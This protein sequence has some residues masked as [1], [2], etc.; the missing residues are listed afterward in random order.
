MQAKRVKNKVKCN[1]IYTSEG[2]VLRQ[3]KAELVRLKKELQ[4]SEERAME[5]KQEIATKEVSFLSGKNLQIS[6]KDR[7]RTWPI[8]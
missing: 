1:E 3:L 8:R 7:R 2:V 5:L 6:M 4:I